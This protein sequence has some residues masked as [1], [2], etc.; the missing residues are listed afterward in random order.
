MGEG[1]SALDVALS[2]CNTGDPGTGFRMGMW[3]TCTHTL[4]PRL[5]RFRDFSNAR[6]PLIS[7]IGVRLSF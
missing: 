6:F 5:T 2:L 1:F 4:F 7:L 3:P